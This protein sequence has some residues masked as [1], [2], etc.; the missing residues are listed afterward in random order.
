[1]ESKKTFLQTYI[2][3]HTYLTTQ[4]TNVLLRNRIQEGAPTHTVP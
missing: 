4:E 3:V 2:A 1:M